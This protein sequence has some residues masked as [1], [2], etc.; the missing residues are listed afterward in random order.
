MGRGGRGIG[1][2]VIGL[3][4]ALL[5]VVA[6]PS[7]AAA[8]EPLP[9]GEAEGVRIVRERG[10]IVVVFTQRAE[11]LRKRVAGK[12]VSVHCWERRPDGISGGG[13]TMRAPKRG[14]RIRT[15]DMTRGMDY[16][17]LW[18]AARTIKRRGSTVKRGRQ[19][20]VAIPLTQEG[21]VFLDEQARA[22]ALFGVLT[23]S[24]LLA[25]EHDRRG[26]LTPA[27]LIDL[28]PARARTALVALETPSDT[29]AGDTIGYYSD[30]AQH[31]AA[32][33]V[34]ASGR[35]LFLEYEGDVLHT[36]IAGY[37]FGGVD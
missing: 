23:L 17:R 11:R 5:L 30:G 2:G 29:P 13:I 25:E 6:L 8:Q 20:L 22:I 7:A 33:A 10:A 37:V 31:A 26:F 36:N 18:L 14:R 9:V 3:T 34:S 27:E 1:G 21:A 4:F 16:C 35:R 32:V 19:H 12:P 28:V 24:G 15:G